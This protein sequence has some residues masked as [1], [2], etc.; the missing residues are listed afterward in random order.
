M[1]LLTL[2]GTFVYA[3]TISVLA[4]LLSYAATCAALPVLRRREDAPPAMFRAPAGVAVS[5]AALI[6]IGWL[7]LHSTAR[8][9]R[10]AAIAA[11]LG[12]LLYLVPWMLGKRARDS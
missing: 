7:L 11:V 3:A 6:L 12:L 10:D 2:S 4:R 9:A 8:Q 5:I 1:L